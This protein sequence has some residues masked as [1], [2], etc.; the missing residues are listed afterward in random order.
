MENIGTSSIVVQWDAVDDSLI[1][2][3]TIV[4]SRA[5]G[6]VRQVATLTE[7]TSYTITGLTLDTVYNITVT[8]ANTCGSG[9]EIVTTVSLSLDTTSTTS[10]IS[11]TV[12]ASTNSMSISI[13]TTSSTI[14]T[15]TTYPMIISTTANA[16]TFPVINPSVTTINSIITIENENIIITRSNTNIETTTITVT[17]TKQF[18]DTV[19]LSTSSVK[20][21]MANKNSKFK[22][23]LMH[24]CV[25]MYD[26]FIHVDLC[27]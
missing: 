18:N 21:N 6:G 1:I 17:I 27:T 15:T 7:Q 2:T 14:V 25:C 3:Y 13:A 16:T 19:F 4:W 9:P 8:A 11:P 22:A 24:G 10:S 23:Q 26:V 12:T 5:G 20:E